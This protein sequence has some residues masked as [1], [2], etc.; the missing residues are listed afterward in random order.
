MSAQ[1][2]NQNFRDSVALSK[3]VDP[4]PTLENLARNTGLGYE[5]VV[6]HALVR[7]ASSGAEALLAWD[8]HALRELIAA[9]KAEEWIKV[10]SIIDWLEAGLE[11]A[12]W[13]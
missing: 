12:D 6:H 2:S 5:E 9:R 13:R 4:R 7:Y 11:S 10:G 3:L 1:E 8:P